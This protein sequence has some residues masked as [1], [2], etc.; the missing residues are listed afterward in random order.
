MVSS[1]LVLSGVAAPPPLEGQSGAAVASAGG[2][3]S[4]ALADRI[5]PEAALKTGAAE[6]ALR[7][8]E[9]PAGAAGAEE[10]LVQLHPDEPQRVW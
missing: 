7:R 2:V 10:I 6:P 8:K 4:T 3:R 5:D 9:E 1:I